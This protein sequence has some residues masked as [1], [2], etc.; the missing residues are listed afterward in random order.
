MM[1]HRLIACHDCDLVQRIPE[2]FDTGVARCT[3]CG[4]VLREKKGYGIDYTLALTLAGLVLFFL[5]NTFPF[6]AFK[7]E[8][9]VRQTVLLTGILELYAHGMGPL[10]VLVLI[11]T[12]AAPLIQLVCLLCILASLKFGYAPWPLP[13]MFRLVHRLQPW[14]MLDVFMLG[15]LVS[16]VKLAKMAE[17]VPGVAL[18][19]FLAFIFVQAAIFAALDPHQIWEKWE[20][21]R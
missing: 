14:S 9:Q 17:I 2:A 6:L 18:Y 21:L 15:I 4:A 10:A 19:S 1:I 16:M 8:S 13:G 12:V 3:R 7:V 5:V 20:V 11:N